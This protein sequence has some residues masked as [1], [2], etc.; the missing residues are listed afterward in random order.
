MRRAATREAA[1]KRLAAPFRSPMKSTVQR[2]AV[3]EV[4][5]LAPRHSARSPS[6]P[7]EQCLPPA[8]DFGLE[9]RRCTCGAR[10]GSDESQPEPLDMTARMLPKSTGSTQRVKS[11]TPLAVPRSHPRTLVRAT[12]FPLYGLAR[13]DFRDHVVLASSPHRQSG[14]SRPLSCVVGDK[15]GKDRRDLDWLCLWKSR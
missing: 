12:S 10:A 5:R 1:R 2:T 3:R 9:G 14:M 8:L 6:V 7:C 13:D 11:S 4:M 15:L